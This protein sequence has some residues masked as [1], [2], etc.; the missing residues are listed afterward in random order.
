MSA[1]PTLRASTCWSSLASLLMAAARL[2]SGIW[3]ARALPTADNGGV[4]FVLWIAATAALVAGMGLSGSLQRFLSEG[5][6]WRSDDQSAATASG[7]STRSG[8]YVTSSRSAYFI[9]SA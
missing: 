9:A 8:T 6:S 2:V 4:I 5:Q 7:W 1:A 3:L